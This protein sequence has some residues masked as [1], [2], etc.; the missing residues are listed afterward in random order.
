MLGEA[1]A[2]RSLHNS[3]TRKLQYF[4]RNNAVLKAVPLQTRADHVVCLIG[5][6]CTSISFESNFCHVA[7]YWRGS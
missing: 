1:K 3:H 7:H 2:D 6:V 4:M 5:A